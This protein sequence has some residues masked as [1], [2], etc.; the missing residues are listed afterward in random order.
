MRTTPLPRRSLIL[1]LHSL[2]FVRHTAQ[3]ADSPRF[4][5]KDGDRVVLIGDTLIERDQEYGYFEARVTYGNPDKTITFR[6]LGWSGDT[7]GG[8]A[9]ARFGKPEEGYRHLVEHVRALEPTV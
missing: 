6:N 5:L 2:L 3:P 9:R 7:V 8:I 1:L 4:A